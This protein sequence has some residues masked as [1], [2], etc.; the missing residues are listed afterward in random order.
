[1]DQ[2]RQIIV[3][4]RD[5]HWSNLVDE[6]EGSPLQDGANPGESRGKIERSAEALRECHSP[7]SFPSNERRKKI[8]G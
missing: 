1:M 7:L 2:V 3:S 4:H 5:Y 6:D 8:F